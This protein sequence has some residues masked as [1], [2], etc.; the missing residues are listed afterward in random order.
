MLKFL[1]WLVVVIIIVA[2]VFWFNCIDMSDFDEE[3]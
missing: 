3:D 1:G 2:V